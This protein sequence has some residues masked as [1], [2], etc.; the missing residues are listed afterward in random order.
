MMVVVELVEVAILVT[1]MMVVAE[2]CVEVD[3]VLVVVSGGA[4]C[5]R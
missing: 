5:D 1:I 3:D 2:E 4:S